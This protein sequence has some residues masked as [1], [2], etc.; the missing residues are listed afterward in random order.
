M[1]RWYDWILAIV[2]ADFMVVFFIRGASAT[3][4]WEP[5]LYG[6]L[7]GMIWNAWKTNYCSFRWQQEH[8]K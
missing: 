2:A 1:I 8:G 7:V 5:L 6:L 4:W 3:T